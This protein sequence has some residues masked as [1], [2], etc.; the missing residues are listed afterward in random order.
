[1]LLSDGENTTRPAPLPL[2]RLA[3]TAGVAIHTV[4]LGTE[5]GAVVEVNGFSVGTTLNADLLKRIADETDGEYHEAPDAA[6][7]AAVYRSID[8]ELEHRKD[9]RE[10][11]APLAAIAGLLLAT[12]SAL[13]TLWLG[14]PL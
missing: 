3:A 14:R 10:L 6:T 9:E 11:T 2:A 5:G 13:S 7:L 4:G 1:M 8:L 12:G